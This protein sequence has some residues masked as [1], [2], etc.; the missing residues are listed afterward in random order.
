MRPANGSFQLKSEGG[1]G[2]LRDR[3]VVIF[4]MVLNELKTVLSGTA[5]QEPCASGSHS[6]LE[7]G[8]DG[9]GACSEHAGLLPK[10]SSLDE[11][12]FQVG[13]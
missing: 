12:R 9:L 11:S 4:L 13:F 2:A 8:S 10:S 7:Q 3:L 1:F 6:V 5:L